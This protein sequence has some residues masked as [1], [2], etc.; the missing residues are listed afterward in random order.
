MSNQSFQP[1]ID[2]ALSNSRKK[3]AEAYQERALRGAEAWQQ[4]YSARQ[5]VLDE[6][7]PI[8]TDLQTALQKARAEIEELRNANANESRA[9]IN[10]QQH[11]CR[12]SL[13]PYDPDAALTAF[14]NSAATKYRL[15][16]S[17]KMILGRI[18]IAAREGAQ[19]EGIFETSFHKTLPTWTV[20]SNCSSIEE[21]HAADAN[22]ADLC[23]AYLLPRVVAFNADRYLPR[24]SAASKYNA[25][26]IFKQNPDAAKKDGIFYNEFWCKKHSEWVPLS[27]KGDW[28]VR[29]G[30]GVDGP[31]IFTTKRWVCSTCEQKRTADR[32]KPSTSNSNN[33]GQTVTKSNAKQNISSPAAAAS[34]AAVVASPAAD[35]AAAAPSPVHKK[36][37]DDDNNEDDDD[38]GC[39]TEH[40]THFNELL[41]CCPVY[42]RNSLGII[43]SH[44]LAYDV[45]LQ[46][47][48]LQIPLGKST[49]NEESVRLERCYGEMHMRRT[50]DL[51]EFLYENKDMALDYHEAVKRMGF[52]SSKLMHPMATWNFLTRRFDSS[53]DKDSFV[54][55]NKKEN[56]MNR[57]LF[58][59][60]SASFLRDTV[61]K[62]RVDN[63]RIP[64]QIL[65]EKLQ[66][67]A[68]L[69]F[70]STYKTAMHTGDDVR[71]IYLGVNSFGQV[72]SA[73]MTPSD[74][75]LAIRPFL[76]E[77]ADRDKDDE[78]TTNGGQIIYTDK[79][80]ADLKL[81][82]SVFGADVVV[83]LDAFHY[84]RRWNTCLK[85]RNHPQAAEM[86]VLSKK[87]RECLFVT[88]EDGTKSI[89]DKDTLLASLNKVLEEAKA[90]PLLKKVI[91][92]EDFKRR[93]KI[94]CKHINCQCLSDPD[95]A[96]YIRHSKPGCK[97]LHTVRGTNVNEFTHHAINA[98]HG[99]AKLRKDTSANYMCF[100]FHDLNY[101]RSIDYRHDTK[102]SFID[103][104]TLY[105][106]VISWSKLHDGVDGKTARNSVSDAAINPKA[107]PFYTKYHAGLRFDESAKCLVYMYDQYHTNVGLA[108]SRNQRDDQPVQEFP[109][110]SEYKKFIK[111]S[112]LHSDVFLRVLSTKEEAPTAAEPLFLGTPKIL[113]VPPS[114]NN[115]NDDDDSALP[116]PLIIQ[117]RRNCRIYLH[118]ISEKQGIYLDDLKTLV[119]NFAA[120]DDASL[121]SV[122]QQ[123]NAES[124]RPC[125]TLLR[126]IYSV[127]SESLILAPLPSVEKA[128]PDD[129]Q[130]PDDAAVIPTFDE[131]LNFVD[132][133]RDQIC[134]TGDSHANL[135]FYLQRFCNIVATPILFLRTGPDFES[136]SG[137]GNQ[138]R[139]DTFRAH[140]DAPCIIPS[141]NLFV[142]RTDLLHRPENILI[143][144]VHH[145]TKDNF[146]IS[147]VG[148]I[149]AEFELPLPSNKVGSKFAK[150]GQLSVT[151]GYDE[152]V[153]DEGATSRPAVVP[154]Q[155]QK[156][157]LPTTLH[158]TQAQVKKQ[159]APD[160]GVKIVSGSHQLPSTRQGKESAI[161]ASHVGRLPEQI[162]HSQNRVVPVGHESMMNKY[163]DIKKKTKIE[164]EKTKAG[165]KEEAAAKAGKKVETS[166]KKGDEPV[167][168]KKIG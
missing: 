66:R 75:Y 146:T 91:E 95:I 106:N 16:D 151:H 102:F 8:I 143:L 81:L 41:Q 117:M 9:R 42:V 10:A 142:G 49:V 134:K 5:G 29:F 83:K 24:F 89:P 7:A 70:D 128:E 136:T 88:K 55:P 27:D 51:Q 166:T 129:L 113:A 6:A 149:A 52:S 79:C 132:Q 101:R 105:R 163:L 100:F 152:G 147:V 82:Q 116:D 108:A 62:N 32:K 37:S 141:K 123:M 19:V 76:Q 33:A 28:T 99:H 112:V 109:R 167:R 93:L 21:R 87:L 44:K 80:C 96:M 103:P 90:D 118:Q 94:Q 13:P 18:V 121:A 84:L 165:K 120:L 17:A 139:K 59:S 57:F 34:P 164:S 23:C 127:T 140:S 11:S 159:R 115:G 124:V 130:E 61:L 50:A 4:Q 43:C 148:V 69:S 125:E 53:E 68:T 158:T 67:T 58:R 65:Q 92:R 54:G 14:L 157:A 60:P 86:M 145:I 85:S 36:N 153:D 63:L 168:A 144:N 39:E 122:T 150:E 26:Q 77:M 64:L 2:Q 161:L 111:Q 160:N 155:Q 12:P 156:A 35:A 78:F 135:A 133:E 71:S 56:L 98:N 31:F 30:Y 137:S 25:R 107:N 1:T 119:S 22:L 104:E 126:V 40:S 74:S 15:A 97:K 110:H 72:I 154:P 138:T 114:T 47:Q 20:P 73:A 131:W 48:L 162:N 45:K 46:Q 38:D 3:N